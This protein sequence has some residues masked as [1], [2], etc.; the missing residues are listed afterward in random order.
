MDAVR[1][2]T[3]AVAVLAEMVKHRADEALVDLQRGIHTRLC[4]QISSE[5]LAEEL[6][7]AHVAIERANEVVAVFMGA[8]RGHI[9]FVAVGVCVARCIHPVA[10]ELLAKMR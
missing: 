1:I 4:E 5:L 7:V 3:A 10:G 6:V 2:E 9:P 8:L